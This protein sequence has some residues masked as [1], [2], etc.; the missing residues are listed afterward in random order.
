MAILRGS[1][2]NCACVFKRFVGILLGPQDLDKVSCRNID[3]TSLSS[4]GLR[5]NEFVTSLSKNLEKSILVRGIYSPMVFPIFTKK[6][7]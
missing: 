1:H 5:N 4:T 6:S 2:R 7:L 3:K